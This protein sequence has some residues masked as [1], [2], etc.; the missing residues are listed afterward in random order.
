VKT[1]KDDIVEEDLLKRNKSTKFNKI[2]NG[3][4]KKEDVGDDLKRHKSTKFNKK[5][6]LEGVKKDFDSPENEIQI[7][8]NEKRSN[9]PKNEEKR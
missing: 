8:S 3:D 7:N 5:I 4:I 2:K 1:K 6:D 9:R